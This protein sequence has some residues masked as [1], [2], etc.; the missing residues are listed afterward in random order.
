MIIVH[1]ETANYS[2][3]ENNNFNQKNTTN[4]IKNK[5]TKSIATSDK[6]RCPVSHT[7]Q[8]KQRNLT[9]LKEKEAV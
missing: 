8:R 3:R 7:K 1:N 5:K 2:G 6:T 4:K 9:N